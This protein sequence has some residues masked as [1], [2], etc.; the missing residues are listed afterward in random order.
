M[1]KVNFRTSDFRR[2]VADA[3]SLVLQ[4]RYFEQN[5]FLTEDGAALL[6]RPGMRRLMR[7]GEGPIRGIHSEP[8]AFGGDLFVVSGREL[9]RV[10]SDLSSTLLYSNLDDPNRGV[11]N[12]AITAEI[13][14]TPEFLFFA[15]G[16]NLFVYVA[17]G[18]ARGLLSGS[19]EVGDVVR[20]DTVYYV[21]SNGDVDLGDPDGS[22]S[23][24][25]R[26]NIGFD[27]FRSF[28]NL[29]HAINASGVAG[30]DYST[31]LSKNGFARAANFQASSIEI[32]AT[33]PGAIGNNV[34]TTTTS[35]TMVW[36]TGGTLTGGGQ[37]TVTQVRTPEDVGVIDVAVINSYVLVLPVQK[38]GYQGRFYWID[39]GEIFIDPLNFATAERSPDGIYGIEVFGDQFWLPGESTTEV[40][41][42]TGDTT[43]PMRRLQGVVLDRGSWQSTAQAIHESMIIVDADGGVFLVRGGSPQRVSTPDIEEEIREAISF[44]QNMI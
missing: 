6:S 8:G 17:E 31:E 32:R 38:D 11:V 18:Y 23:N 44:Q 39:P 34:I 21:F 12:M 1:V 22:S 13:G 35:S 20:I 26:V 25:W 40:W 37:G 42:V 5:P 33:Q 16:R 30:T 28:E 29:Y 14:D 2:Q 4:N 24:P 19:P 41:Y 9:Y 15:D 7:L 3:G 43:F 36:S 27:A 10:S